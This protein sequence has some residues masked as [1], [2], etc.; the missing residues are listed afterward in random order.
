MAEGLSIQGP[1][2]L[3]ITR[4]ASLLRPVGAADRSPQAGEKAGVLPA[5]MILICHAC[6]TYVTR[7]KSVPS[8]TM[9]EGQRHAGC[10]A[11]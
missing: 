5:G 11:A 9:L 10:E 1:A 3:S 8:A 2:R 7:C 6:I 4:L